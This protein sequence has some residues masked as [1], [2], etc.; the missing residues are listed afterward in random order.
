M[1]LLGSEAPFCTPFSGLVT[2]QVGLLI[3]H[4]P[5]VSRTLAS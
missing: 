1:W 5:R 3:A 2:L 4:S